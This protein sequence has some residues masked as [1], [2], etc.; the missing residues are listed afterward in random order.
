MKKREEKAAMATVIG[1]TQVFGGHLVH[2]KALNALRA[3]IEAEGEAFRARAVAFVEEESSDGRIGC[4]MSD[5]K[6]IVIYLGSLLEESKKR[7][8][9]NPNGMAVMAECWVNLIYVMAHEIGHA[10]ADVHGEGATKEE[11]EASCEEYGAEKFEALV[12]S[13]E[14]D[15]EPPPN[16]E[17]PFLPTRFVTWLAKAAEEEKLRPWVAKQME[18]FDADAMFDPEAG[19]VDTMKSFI[20]ACPGLEQRRKEQ[21]SVEVKMSAPEDE[22]APEPR[23]SVET[24]AGTDPFADGAGEFAPTLPRQSDDEEEEEEPF[25]ES[26]EVEKRS[27]AGVAPNPAEE[28]AWKK[29]YLALDTS[30][31]E[32]CRPENPAAGAESLRADPPRVD[33]ALLAEVGFDKCRWIQLEN[34]NEKAKWAWRERPIEDGV[35]Q[36]VIFKT[37]KLPSFHLFSSK[38]NQWVKVIPQNPATGSDSAKEAKRGNRISFVIADPAPGSGVKD[39]QFVGKIVNGEYERIVK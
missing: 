37:S 3:L 8:L 1:E 25:F 24:I 35:I 5:L 33:P 32:K 15:V 30:V 20:D 22:P 19:S 26:D 2:P 16:R 9:E 7:C 10:L 29:I 38:A 39:S 36:C 14:V 31:W 21:S 17:V 13:N 12:E 4:W 18:M 27:A 28:P 34:P 6:M 11:I 23:E